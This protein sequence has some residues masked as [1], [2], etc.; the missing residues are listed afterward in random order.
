[1]KF[2]ALSNIKNKLAP[3]MLGAVQRMQRAF[4]QAEA[5]LR[6]LLQE[7]PSDVSGWYNLG[8]VYIDQ[9]RGQQVA[10]VGQR[11]LMVPGGVR[12]AG[13]LAVLWQL[14]RGDPALAGPLLNQVIADAPHSPRPRMLRAEWLSRMQAPIE[15]QIQALRDIL[16]VQPGNVEARQWIEKAQRFQAAQ[17]YQSAQAAPVA[18]PWFTS[19]AI[20]GVA[21]E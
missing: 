3:H 12:D 17:A 2:G 10:E 6:A 16:R 19:V 5:T 20:A 9:G 8:L 13:L 18:N 7:F 4:D 15:A 21:A 14:R 11:L 1:M